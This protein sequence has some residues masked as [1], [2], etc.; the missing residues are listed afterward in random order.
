MNYGFFAKFLLR[1]ALLPVIAGISY[2]LLKMS[3]KYSDHKVMSKLI[4]PGLWFQ[5]LTTRIPDNKQI[6]VS[7]AALTAA[8][9]AERGRKA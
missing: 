2:E 5:G 3:A 7:I 8:L 6:E 4:M 9:K 1:I